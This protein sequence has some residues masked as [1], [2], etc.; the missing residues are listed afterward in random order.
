MSDLERRVIAA[1]REGDKRPVDTEAGRADLLD[2]V[3]QLGVESRRGRRVG[4]LAVAAVLLLLLSAVAVI[5]LRP[6]EPP[7]R[8]APASTLASGL[9]IGRLSANLLIS[10]GGHEPTTNIFSLRV[11]RD[12]TGRY[13]APLMPGEAFYPVRF[14]GSASGVVRIVRLDPGACAG[15]TEVTLHFVRIKAGIRITAVDPAGCFTEPYVARQ[16]AGTVLTWYP[17]PAGDR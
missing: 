15:Q 7:V 5:N 2:V 14:V 13:T 6:S 8:S 3:G 12:G 16:L 1:L 11:N 9:P 17:V 10:D 4:A